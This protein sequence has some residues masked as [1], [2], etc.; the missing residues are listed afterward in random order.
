MRPDDA[1]WAAR[2]VAA[3]SDELIRAAVSAGRYSNAKAAEHLTAVL[4]KRRNRIAQTYLPAINPIVD[5]VLD[6][7][8]TLSFRNAAVDHAGATAPRRYTA[9]WF[10]FDNTSQ[11]SKDVG[12]T[13]GE[14]TRVAAPAGLPADV[15]AFVRV[16][17]KAEHETLTSWG[18]PVE[19]YFRRDVSGWT[20]VGL[21]RLPGK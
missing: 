12:V 3:F 21:T 10:T 17:L 13:T 14:A 9:T 1:F 4:I 11:A 19:T 7:A 16:D 8:G 18:R 15:G 5:P 2:R 6:G 20:L